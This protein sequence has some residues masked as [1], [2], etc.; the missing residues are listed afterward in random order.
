MEIISMVITDLTIKNVKNGLWA[1][2]YLIFV[3]RISRSNFS[4]NKSCYLTNLNLIISETNVKSNS[5]WN[6]WLWKYINFMLGSSISWFS[7]NSSKKITS[8][9]TPPWKTPPRQLPPEKLPGNY[10]PKSSPP[11]QIALPPRILPLHDFPPANNSQRKWR[12]VNT[13]IVSLKITQCRL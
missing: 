12:N 1:C 8:R 11:P 7:E 6:T 13:Y 5:D 10:S 4:H 9:N 2:T 3:L